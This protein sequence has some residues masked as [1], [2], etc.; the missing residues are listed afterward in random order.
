MAMSPQSKPNQDR[1]ITGVAGGEQ[2]ADVRVF[3]LATR[4][5][6]NVL[7]VGGELKSTVCFHTAGE[8]VLT[9]PAGDLTDPATYRRFL[10]RIAELTQRYGFRPE[11]IAHDLHPR[12][13]STQYALSAGIPTIAVQH[14]HA[15]LV[16]VMAEW[17]VDRPV[18]GICC[19]GVG[20]G[21][22]GAAWGCEVLVCETGGFERAGHLDYFPLLGGDAAA[23]EPCR[24]AAALLMQAYGA[25]WRQY[26]PVAFSG[27][28][29]QDL[30]V[31]DRL[32]TTRTNSPPTSSLG[33]VF[34]GVSFLLGLCRRNEREAQAAIALECAAEGTVTESYPYETTVENG[35]IKMSMAPVIRAIVQDFAAGT[36]AER[37]S[38]CFHETV[39]R[40]LATTAEI[41][42]EKKGI[43]TL[44]VSGGCFAN[45][46]LLA[47]VTERLQ[48]RHFNVLVPR[49]VS[50][51][52]AGLALGQA[53]AAAAM[54][55]RTLTC[56]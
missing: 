36:D 53:V 48:R 31:L 46:R 56:A 13:M 4:T 32:L 16:S 50:C 51:G 29:E 23:L 54:N 26:F 18:V 45:K 17:R 20:Y 33:R 11:L 37:I 6:R 42:C 7:A 55:E 9:Q 15:H 41:V 27:L 38:A 14:H 40:M 24:P 19:D 21:S 30:D 22:D 2:P 25:D 12:Y 5:G 52:D 1:G 49:L 10:D 35:A 3:K 39:A 34:D 47:R 8:A 44:S 43:S 28:S